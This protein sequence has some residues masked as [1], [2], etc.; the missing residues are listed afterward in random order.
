M[1]WGGYCLTKDAL[2]ASWAKQNLISNGDPLLQSERAININDQMPR[3]AFEFLYKQYPLSNANILL[4]GVS[5]RG[6]VGDTRSSPVENLHNYLSEEGANI[7]CHDPYV[8]YWDEKSIKINQELPKLLTNSLDIIIISAGHSIYNSEN[9]VDMI[10]DLEPL[11]IYDTIGHLS[12]NQLDK[13]KKRHTVKVLGR[14][15]L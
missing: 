10:M 14:G 8:N 12:Q 2:L 5:Y 4:L 7:L 9:N 15:D 13:L 11:F 3:F 1:E 6:D